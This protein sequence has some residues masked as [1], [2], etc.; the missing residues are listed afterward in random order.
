MAAAS[1][2]DPVHQGLQRDILRG[3]KQ[4]VDAKAILNPGAPLFF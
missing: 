4:V 3:V 2:W 1:I